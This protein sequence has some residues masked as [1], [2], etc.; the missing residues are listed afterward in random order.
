[1]YSQEGRNAEMSPY[2][3]Y[4]LLVSPSVKR[5]SIK[6]AEILSFDISMVKRSSTSLEQNKG[7]FCFTVPGK[8]IDSDSYL[9]FKSIFSFL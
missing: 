4:G 1:M 8:S 3:A 6:P 5:P 2:R 7:L 9:G